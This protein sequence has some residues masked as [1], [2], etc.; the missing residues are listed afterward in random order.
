MNK[1]VFVIS[2]RFDSYR[3]LFKD[4]YEGLFSENRTQTQLE[5]ELLELESKFP[6]T[7][8]RSSFGIKLS[9]ADLNQR[10]VTCFSKDFF[11]NY[12]LGVHL[13]VFG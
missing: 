13:W 10:H 12:N 2:R 8:K 7:F 5:R 3:K 11:Y 1:P 9:D 4:I 6:R